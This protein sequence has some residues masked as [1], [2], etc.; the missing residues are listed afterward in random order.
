MYATVKLI[1]RN[2][3]L[4]LMLIGTK[5]NSQKHRKMEFKTPDFG[6]SGQTIR[7]RRECGVGQ[8]RVLC[9]IQTCKQVETTAR[10]FL[11]PAICFVVLFSFYFFVSFQTV[12][13]DHPS[14]HYERMSVGRVVAGIRGWR[15]C[16]AGQVGFACG[17][18]QDLQT[19]RCYGTLLCRAR[20]LF[21]WF[22]FLTASFQTVCSDHHSHH[23][24]WAWGGWLRCGIKYKGNQWLQVRRSDKLIF[25]LIFC[26]QLRVSLAQF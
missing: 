1:C 23:Y 8:A 12:C 24:E 4:L 3:K 17:S 26:L 25:T 2:N 13:S 16:G 19:G 9:G 5:P 15:E 6:D 18:D 21:R 22:Y 20:R 10:C 14:H 7:G 11:E